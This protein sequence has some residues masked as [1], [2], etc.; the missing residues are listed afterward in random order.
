MS[1]E[2]SY[3]PIIPPKSKEQIIQEYYSEMENLIQRNNELEIQ[4]NMVSRSLEQISKRIVFIGRKEDKIKIRED[5]IDKTVVNTLN[6]D[7]DNNEQVKRTQSKKG[8]K[9]VFERNEEDEIRRVE[10]KIKSMIF[11]TNEEV[12]EAKKI[13]DLI[14][15]NE[16]CSK[17]VL[18]RYRDLVDKLEHVTNE[19]R[20]ILTE[21]T[22]GKILLGEDGIYSYEEATNNINELRKC[23][24]SRLENDYKKKIFADAC[25]QVGFN[26][27]EIVCN[28]KSRYEVDGIDGCEVE[29]NE[30]DNGEIMLETIGVIDSNENISQNEKREYVNKS[31][32][33]CDKINRLYEYIKEK[34]PDVELKIGNVVEPDENNIKIR[35]FENKNKRYECYK[36]QQMIE[37]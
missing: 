32:K 17:E 36:K 28:G 12:D 37:E 14:H 10:D 29:V 35:Y 16:K 31:R 23:V 2:I 25:E 26:M 4:R 11:R 6:T 5:S 9:W 3:I 13:I 27:K 33:V 15:I 18:S 8:E 22:M 20:N 1:S 34:Y 30:F 21:Y 24:E 19:E 7:Y